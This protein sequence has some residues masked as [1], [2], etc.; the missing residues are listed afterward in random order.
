MQAKW[1]SWGVAMVSLFS[2]VS[3]R[4][5]RAQCVEV[6]ARIVREPTGLETMTLPPSVT[7]AC[8]GSTIYL[9]LWVINSGPQTPGVAGG[10]VDI[11]FDPA[12]LQ[13]IAID[14][15]THFDLLPVGGIENLSGVVDDVGGHTMDAGVAA[16]P[17]WALLVRVSFV[18]QAGGDATMTLAPGAFRFALA[19]GQSP[20]QFGQDV[21]LDPP[22]LVHLLNPGVE[23]DFDCDGDVDLMDYRA[24]QGCLYGPE[25][26]GGPCDAVGVD[27][28][29]DADV[30]L[31]DMAI[32]ET[33]FSG[34]GG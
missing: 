19:G 3:M 14:H 27:L 18:V 23:G 11:L 9:E 8:V 1:I 5:C 34:A 13:G 30:D 24:F 6:Q 7:S 2:C 25:N 16:T 31:L 32:F 12:M 28:D 26:L 15:Q 4:P 33:V 10:S 21:L 17:V 29:G 22:V 20:L